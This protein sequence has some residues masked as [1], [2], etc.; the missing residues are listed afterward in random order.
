MSNALLNCLGQ[1]IPLLVGIATIPLIIRGLGPEAF[2]VLGLIWVLMGYFSAFDLGLGRATTKYTAQYLREGQS[3]RLAGLIWSSLYLNLA[4]GIL[5]GAVVASLAPFLVDKVFAIPGAL[6]R[7]TVLSFYLLAATLPA[8]L[9][10]MSLRGVLEGSQRFDLVNVVKVPTNASLFVLP[11][12]GAACGL[13]LSG[14]VALLMLATLAASLA[15]FAACRRAF[16]P[17]RQRFRP[18]RKSITSLFGYGSWVAVSSVVSPILVYL[19]RFLIASLLSVTALAYYTAPYEMI[20]RL[21]IIPSSL[22]AVLFPA[23]SA[24]GA[25][26]SREKLEDLYARSIK[27]LA[28]SVGPVVV[29]LIV[30]AEP[31]LQLWLG[32]DFARHSTLVIQILSV[33]VFANSLAQVPHSLILGFG[34]PDLVAKSHIAELVVYVGLVWLLINEAGLA[35]AALAWATRMVLDAAL[36]FAIA[37]RLRLAAAPALRGHGLW[38]ATLII[39]LLGGAAEAVTLA[40]QSELWLL[41]SAVFLVLLA[42]FAVGVWHWAF[43]AHDRHV[44]RFRALHL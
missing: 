33:G 35:G 42:V 14:V 27:Y 11:A 3:E 29:G 19:D 24:L 37:A 23:F 1:A 6:A 31:L 28:V 16:L 43:D 44:F 20:V 36:L 26:A 15:Y 30:F 32:T 18:D 40:I 21:W 39:C 5:G 25:S 2:G 38:R 12:V 13:N 22:V 4:L 9:L 34:R 10:S 7:E 8:V 17:L 41:K